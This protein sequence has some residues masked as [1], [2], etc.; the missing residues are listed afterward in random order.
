MDI[1][2]DHEKSAKNRWIRADLKNLS[3]Q[4]KCDRSEVTNILGKRSDIEYR[5]QNG[6]VFVRLQMLKDSSTW[7]G[8]QLSGVMQLKSVRAMFK[9]GLW[10]V[11]LAPNQINDV[12]MARW[13]I[14]TLWEVFSYL[15]LAVA[16]IWMC[17]SIWFDIDCKYLSDFYWFQRSGAVLVFA[18]AFAEMMLS[19]YPLPPIYANHKGVIASRR[20][21]KLRDTALFVGYG[22]ITI[23]TLVWAYGDFPFHS[24]SCC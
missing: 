6:K 17:V 20:L 22:M 12:R 15:V 9:L 23:G 4:L 3:S 18:G 21:H 7:I 19:R 16:L 13:A 5:V 11:D 1:E 14:R 2:K 8:P 24:R 10:K